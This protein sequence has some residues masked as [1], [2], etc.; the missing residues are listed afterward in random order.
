MNTGIMSSLIVAI[1][2][3]GL[4][5]PMP[6]PAESVTYKWIDQNQKTHYGNTKPEGT[7][8]ETL[9]INPKASSSANAEIQK[10][11]DNQKTEQA[12]E[13]QNKLTQEQNNKQKE[14]ADMN[15]KNCETA[16]TNLSSLTERRRLRQI[17]KSGDLEIMPQEAL[18]KAV[19]TAQENIKKYCEP[20][21]PS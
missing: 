12:Q 5:Y 16:K 3:A 9:K 10:L 20:E 14:N 8:F 15:A 21:L 6:S 11:K 13:E 18:D 2:I 4:A 1:G 7:K 19:A 17:G